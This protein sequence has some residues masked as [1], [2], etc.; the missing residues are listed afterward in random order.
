[1][2]VDGQR[3][4]V[5]PT[6][7]YLGVD[8]LPGRHTYRFVFNPWIPKVGLAVSGLTWLGLLIYAVFS[9]VRLY[10]Q[11]PPWVRAP[12]RRARPQKAGGI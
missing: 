6:S 5:M 3:R 2:W 4:Q 1:V 11:R 8:T 9:G 10:R 7:N 12:F